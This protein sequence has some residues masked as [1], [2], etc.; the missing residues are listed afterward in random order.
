MC[1]GLEKHRAPAVEISLFLMVKRHKKR[2]ERERE[3][4]KIIRHKSIVNDK[5]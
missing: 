2:R 5:N 1:R 3:I 4:K